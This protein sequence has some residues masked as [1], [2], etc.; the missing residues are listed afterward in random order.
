MKK[1]CMLRAAMC[2]A[3]AV[4]F[5]INAPDVKAESDNVIDMNTGIAGMSE[6]MDSY[7]EARFNYDPDLSP[8]QVNTDMSIGGTRLKAISRV[9]SPYENLAIANVTDY[10]NIR[11]GPSVD[12]EKVG[13]LYRGCVADVIEIEG[14]W[15]KIN[16]GSVEGG[17]I[18][19]EYLLFGEE[20]EELMEEVCTKYAEVICTTLNVRAGQSTDEKIVTQIP[21]GEQ[22]IIREEFDEW[23]K[24]VLGVDDVTGEETYG[25]VSKDYI[26][27]NYDFDYAISREEEEAELAR[28]EAA[29]KAEEAR[30]AELARQQAASSGSSSSNSSSSGSSSSGSSS[31]GS[32]SS[33]SGQVSKPDTSAT[34]LALGQE[35]ADYA[36]QFVGNPYKWGG[37]SLTNGADCS[38]FVYAVYKQFGYTLPRVSR[39]QSKSAGVAEVT[40]NLSNLQPGDLIFYGDSSGRVDHVAMYIGNGKVVHASNY[41]EGI[42]ISSYN[43]RTPINARRIVQ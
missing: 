7:Y 14:D 6:M 32:S 11:S 36:V 30:L 29:K 24:I 37:T 2:L 18:N 4:F 16:S 33:S 34:G 3:A 25:Y 21:L 23:A 42:K 35:I 38:G 28:I 19:K 9:P 43:Y 20:A 41:R 5:S 12:S 10:V 1:S 40:P 8:S 31:S 26:T 39:D 27:I 15:V 13:K 22:Y 17:Y